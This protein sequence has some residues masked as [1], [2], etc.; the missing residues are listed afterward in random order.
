MLIACVDYTAFRGTGIWLWLPLKQGYFVY[1]ERYAF[2]TLAK[3][4][5]CLGLFIVLTTK[6]SN[7]I[8]ENGLFHNEFN[9]NSLCGK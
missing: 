2:P 7:S 1:M 9:V 5:Q 8:I 6:G 3:N 4:G